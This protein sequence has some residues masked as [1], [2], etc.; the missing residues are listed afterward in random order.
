MRKQ[1]LK[2]EFK[3]LLCV[4]ALGALAFA[5]PGRAGAQEALTLN[6]GV[7]DTVTLDFG[8]APTLAGI[9]TTFIYSSSTPGLLIWDGS[10]GGWSVNVVSGETYPILGSSSNPV[11][12]LS[13]TD[14]DNS[15]PGTN[16][17]T[18][19]LSDTGYTTPATGLLA[20]SALNNI[21]NNMSV[22]FQTEQNATVLT[23]TYTASA[24]FAASNYGSTAGVA[25]ADT[26]SEIITVSDPDGR[27]AADPSLELEEIPEPSA[28]AFCLISL[29]LLALFLRRKS[30][31]RQK[32]L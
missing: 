26:L 4:L 1:N 32:C 28:L 3:S 10:V 13:A 16:V 2:N 20:T 23:G 6:D 7:G 29:P 15:A 27:G 21:S 18:L 25:P 9:A 8:S 31:A 11:L 17:L 19:T 22:L 14:I 5:L 24:P 12:N 30:A